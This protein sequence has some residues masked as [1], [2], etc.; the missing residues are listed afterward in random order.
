MNVLVWK[1]HGNIKVYAADTAEQVAGIVDT[2]MSCMN[3]EGI[4]SHTFNLVRNHIEK[5][6][7]NHTEMVR[8][9][10]TLRNTVSVTRRHGTFEDIFLTQVQLECN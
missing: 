3:D 2:M 5:H 9:F 4:E 1:S 10:N 6:K 8:A 7:G